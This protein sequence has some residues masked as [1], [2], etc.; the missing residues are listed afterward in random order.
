MTNEKISKKYGIEPILKEMWVWDNPKIVQKQFV[1]GFVHRGC[2]GFLTIKDMSIVNFYNNASETNPNDKEPK[3][4][5][6]GYF[7]DDEGSYTY[8]NLKNYT[9]DFFQSNN[10]V[11]FKH[12]SHEKQPWML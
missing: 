10:I 4:G 8:G 6:K 12:F 11:W 1:I 7:W 3:V 5:D 2:L 9:T